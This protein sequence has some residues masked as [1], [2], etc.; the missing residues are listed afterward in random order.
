[1]R[2]IIILGGLLLATIP[3]VA[4]NP[5]AWKLLPV[6]PPQPQQQ[7][8]AWRLL[9]VA[10]PQPQQAAPSVDPAT[11]QQRAAAI[12]QALQI[13]QM[14]PKPYQPPPPPVVPDPR[15]LSTSCTIIGTQAY[16]YTQR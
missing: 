11:A 3:A 10:P 16:C 8:E 15:G 2:T 7:Q 13:M 6:A 4:Q 12:L 5:E 9:P 1:M 14:M